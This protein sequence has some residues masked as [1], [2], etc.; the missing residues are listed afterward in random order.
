MPLREPAPE[1]LRWLRGLA[2]R[3]VRDPHLADDAVQSTLLVALERRP[4]EERSPREWLRVVLRNVLRQEW[5]SRARRAAREAGSVSASSE[6]STLEVVE[7]LALHRRL[8]ERVHALDEPYRTAIVLHFLRGRTP[9]EIA[10]EQALPVKTVRTRIDRGVVKLRERLGRDREAWLVFLLE[11][12]NAAPAPLPFLLP[13]KLQAIAA[14]LALPLVGVFLYV[15]D[16]ARGERGLPV[17]PSGPASNDFARLEPRPLA[18]A[19]RE[20]RATTS[21]QDTAHGAPGVAASGPLV[22]GFVRQFDGHGLEG[23]GV[24]FESRDAGG[25]SR[26]G[27]APRTTSGPA[28]A[29]T[30]PLPA[31]AGR[32]GVLADEYVA[33]VRP[34]LDGSAPLTEPIVVVAP[35]RTYAGLVVDPAGGA[36]AG[37]RVE[38]TL[39]GPFVQSLDVGGA[40]V[41]CLLPF[42][43][44]VS[45][46]SGR[47]RFERAGFVPGA[48]LEACADG[49][50]PGRLEL[51]PHSDLALQFVLEGLAPGARTIFGRVVDATGMPATGAEVSIGGPAVRSDGD[52]HFTLECEPWRKSGR[53]RAVKPGALPGELS[54]QQAIRPSSPERRVVLQLGGAPR[55]IRGRLLDTLGAPVRGALVWTGDTTSFGSVLHREGENAFWTEATVEGVLAQR[56]APWEAALGTRTDSE[57]RFALEHMIERAYDLFALDPNTLDGLGPVEAWG[58]DENLRLRLARLPGTAVAGRVVSRSGLPLAGVSVDPGRR[59]AWREDGVDNTSWTAIGRRTR[60]VTQSFAESGVVTDAEGRFALPPL[61]ARGAFLALHG[62]ALVL[63]QSFAFDGA[64]DAGQDPTAIEVVVDAGSRFRVRLARSNEADSFRIEGREGEELP[65]YIEVEGETISAARATIE[66]G[67]SGVVLVEEGEHTLV[68]SLGDIEV[69]RGRHAFPAGGLHQL[70]L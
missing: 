1:D 26:A 46:D 55:S 45:D 13:M 67:R 15:R 5:R 47:F 32:L 61:V 6:R 41:H 30:L 59:L 38:I 65:L 23:L 9:D 24:V 66:A 33:V 36:I 3:L 4:G 69:R 39:D 20:A 52:G 48:H 28:G 19:P 2:A 54:F 22:A 16:V 31:S 14:V 70:D 64:L 12:R 43:E 10:R 49:H 51:P 29:F 56:T 40:A 34:H 57:G 53:L 17:P 8:V 11:R 44:A 58:G 27:D 60:F 25:D 68:L 18:S 35:S 63:G 7:E 50:R 21:T 37:A 62:R 42:A